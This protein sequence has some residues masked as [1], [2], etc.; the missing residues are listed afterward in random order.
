MLVPKRT[1]VPPALCDLVG[2][3]HANGSPSQPGI[4][5]RRQAW[6][7]DFPEHRDML[8]AL[9]DLL[10][11][12]SLQRTCSEAVVDAPSAER[13]FIAVMAWGY[14]W[15]G[16]GR[17]RTRS[18]L[19]ETPGASQ[20]LAD[21]ARTLSGDGPLAAYR[22]LASTGDC[23]LRGFGPAFGTK[24]LYFC[25]PR[26]SDVTALIH[27]RLVSDWLLR[28]ANLTLSPGVWSVT[29][30]ARYLDL[31]HDW[32]SS[33]E[34]R[35]DE[36]EY[37]MFRAVATER[38]NQWGATS[39]ASGHR[40]GV[41]TRLRRGRERGVG[42]AVGGPDQTGDDGGRAMQGQ[43][44][45]D[46]YLGLVKAA[47]EGLTVAYSDLAGRGQIGGYL[48]RIADYEKAHRRPPLTALAVHKQTGRPGEG[49][50]IAAA[51]VGYARPGESKSDVWERAV[52]EVF[53]YW[54]P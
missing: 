40:T 42:Q 11:R 7:V 12:E 53:A 34:C 3:W 43:F 52:A 48:Y 5:F 32:A 28:E 19:T 51:Q 22:R 20:R 4:D 46:V 18:I 6:I 33:L 36:L 15:V 24:Y 50:A 13:A 23:R 2:L 25:Q 49:F 39:H 41:S 30:Y 29:T 44:S 45:T 38:G 10:D 14:G 21:V 8:R 54:K 17:F 47:I 35:P 9:P 37:C 1:T 27:D 31:M 16:Y 26:R